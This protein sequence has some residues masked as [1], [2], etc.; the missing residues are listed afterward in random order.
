MSF[1][2]GFFRNEKHAKSVVLI[3][4]GANSVAGAYAQYVVDEKPILLYTCRASISMRKDEPHER[5]MLRALKTL[6]SALILEGAPILMRATGSGSADTILVSID[7]PW[8]KTSVRTEHFERKTPFVFTKDMVATALQRAGIT[9]PG[10]LLADESIIGTILN[11]YETRD[12][13]GKKA[14]RAAVIILTSLIDEHIAV[15]IAALLRGLYHATHILFIAG[16]SLRYQAIRTVFPHERDALILDATGSLTSA[17]LVRNNLFIALAEVS[18]G[19]ARS[20]EW[21]Q[22]IIDE[23]T[24]LAE[25]YPLPRTIFLLAQEAK[26]SSLHKVF[27]TIHFKKLWLS[28]NPPK[29]VSVLASHIVGLIRQAATASP[30]L[31]LLLMALFWQYHASEEKNLIHSNHPALH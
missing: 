16:S 29:I 6:C 24:T 21:A 10:K 28:D 18:D 9:V 30:D 2:S 1:F 25:N 15:G 26:T 3:D 7:A 8:Q 19:V 12:P 11:G 5:A 13:Y 17:A 14:H 20:D 27:G 23:F 31:Q 4:I 22:K